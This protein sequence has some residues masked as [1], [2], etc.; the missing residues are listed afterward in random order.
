MEA[1]ETATADVVVRPKPSRKLPTQRYSSGMAVMS[2]A[3]TKQALQQLRLNAIHEYTRRSKSHAQGLHAPASL[4]SK[5]PAEAK[6]AS[7]LMPSSAANRP[8]S[9]DSA[10][11][12]EE[13][14]G[15]APLDARKSRS[16]V[17][18][19]SP[20]KFATP[21]PK[22]VSVFTD[23]KM[24]CLSPIPFCPESPAEGTP[25]IIRAASRAAA[26]RRSSGT[27]G[28][29]SH[30]DATARASYAGRVASS[31]EEDLV[32]MAEGEAAHQSPPPKDGSS[33]SRDAASTSM[34]GDLI[35]APSDDDGPGEQGDVDAMLS[36]FKFAS[37]ATR[38][39]EKRTR[40]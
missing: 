2:E 23:P 24:D 5:P 34:L 31:V 12:K 9:S 6:R 14:A 30:G 13:P 11:K 10:K 39:R 20:L 19:V 16:R 22:R 21:E 27:R 15:R 25:S 33:P 40:P 32:A 17:S 4:P 28:A 37:H 26:E 3:S 7:P 38:I 36:P 35:D 8:G 29:R 18:F 1:A